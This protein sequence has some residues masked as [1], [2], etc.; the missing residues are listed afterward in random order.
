MSMNTLRKF[1]LRKISHN[2]WKGATVP[3]PFAPFREQKPKKM[4]KKLSFSKKMFIFAQ[5]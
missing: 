5:T 1:S 3:D 2:I 4:T